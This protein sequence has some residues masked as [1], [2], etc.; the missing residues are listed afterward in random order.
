LNSENET[1][2]TSYVIAGKSRPELTT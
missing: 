1:G 2:K